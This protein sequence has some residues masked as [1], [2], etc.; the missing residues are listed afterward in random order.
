MWTLNAFIWRYLDLRASD[1][2]IERWT[3]MTGVLT[4]LLFHGHIGGICMSGSLY[5]TLI[6]RCDGGCLCYANNAGQSLQINM[7][8]D[9]TN[10][11]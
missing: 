9:I 3:K 4:I 7:K 10:I 11:S 2:L 1:W 6:W 5:F 8:D